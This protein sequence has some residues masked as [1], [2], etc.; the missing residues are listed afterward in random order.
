V[1]TR[2][3]KIVQTVTVASIVLLITA[4][5]AFAGPATEAIK[6]THAKVLEVLHDKEMKKPERAADRKEQLA[7]V[8]AERFSCTDMAR[9]ILAGQWSVLGEDKR[10]DFIQLFRHILLRTYIHHIDRYAD[11]YVEYLGESLESGRALVRTKVIAR[12]REVLLDFWLF[13]GSGDWKVYDVV[14][15]GVSLIQNY[16]GQFTRALRM[17]SYADLL[18]RMR[19]KVCIPDCDIQTALSPSR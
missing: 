16:R 18:E 5:S 15:D 10:D 9:Q 4:S 11:Q 6:R 14:V 3:E 17:F 2:F 19:E 8:I 1:V 12:E 13:E 7:M